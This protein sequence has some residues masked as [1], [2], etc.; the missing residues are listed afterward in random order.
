M[1]KDHDFHIT[2]FIFKVNDVSML[3]TVSHVTAVFETS[4]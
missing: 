4:K 1:K 2:K 3:Q